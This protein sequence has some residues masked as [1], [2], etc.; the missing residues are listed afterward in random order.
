[1]N[2]ASHE[3][4][5]PMVNTRREKMVKGVKVSLYIVFDKTL[6][7]AHSRCLE[8]RIRNDIHVLLPDD[9][10]ICFIC[11]VWKKEGTSY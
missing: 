2:N 4:R 8:Q 5:Q 1:M 9:F 6:S 11:P 7:R 3:K 10:W